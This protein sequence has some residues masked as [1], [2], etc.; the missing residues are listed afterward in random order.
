MEGG[1][2]PLGAPSA[3]CPGASLVTGRAWHTVGVP[4]NPGA[5]LEHSLLLSPRP[6]HCRV[7]AVLDPRD[8][9]GRGSCPHPP[10]PRESSEGPAGERRGDRSPGLE[11]CSPPLL[12][13]RA[14]PA[15]PTGSLFLGREV[16]GPVLSCRRSVQSQSSWGPQGA[17]GRGWGTPVA[18]T[19]APVSAGLPDQGVVGSA[20]RGQ[21]ALAAGPVHAGLP[22]A[23]HGPR[24]LQVP[25]WL[26]AG[27]GA[28][29][30][31][32]L[33]TVTDPR[34]EGTHAWGRGP[35][36]RDLLSPSTRWGRAPPCP[37]HPPWPEYFAT[38]RKD[39]EALWGP[40]RGAVWLSPR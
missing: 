37:H 32:V 35:P 10:T 29:G 25:D 23:L 20:L 15:L 16:T 31:G 9:A 13:G 6:Q 36:G 26:R 38:A 39:P 28:G 3:G 34:A 8:V 18:L 24:L 33:A 30:L 27:P 7:P 12:S 5:S 40:L 1:G 22:A 4:R 2:H 14:G 17:R 21:R 11:P 19:P